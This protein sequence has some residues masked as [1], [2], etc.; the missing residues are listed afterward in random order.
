V[1]VKFKN[2]YKYQ[3]NKKSGSGA[4]VEKTSWFKF[5]NQT[6]FNEVFTE[7]DD[8]E[9]KVFIFSL[10]QASLNFNK[11]YYRYNS[12]VHTAVC[13]VVENTFSRALK[14]LKRLRVIE[15]RAD[16]GCY[17]DVPSDYPR[18][19]E[20]RLEENRREEYVDKVDPSALFSL[21]NEKAKNLP[22][23][24]KLS[25]QRRRHAKS[26]LLE[27]PDIA[28]WGEVISR[29]ADSK[30]CNG[31]GSTG[32]IA[33]FDFFLKPETHLRVMEGKYDDRGSSNIQKTDYEALLKEDV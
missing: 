7:L 13:G 3:N 14:K 29:M 33:D 22:K 17:A 26:R 27:N 1:I 19:E 11:G 15:L 24:N 8:A 23:A 9:F 25:A 2:W 6:I 10:C 31:A 21:W 20:I 30:F 12:R 28:Y 32:W 5:Y 16:R 18:L 4:L